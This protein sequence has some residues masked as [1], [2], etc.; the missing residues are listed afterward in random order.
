VFIA[1]FMLSEKGLAIEE[2]L[3]TLWGV[4]SIDS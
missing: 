4:L 1:A 3:R 2:A